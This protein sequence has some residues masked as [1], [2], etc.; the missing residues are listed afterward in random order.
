MFIVVK[1]PITIEIEN[2]S[3]LVNVCIIHTNAS[4]KNRG[5]I[6]REPLVPQGTAPQECDVLCGGNGG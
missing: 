6:A 5:W 3:L 2:A 4:V 1:L